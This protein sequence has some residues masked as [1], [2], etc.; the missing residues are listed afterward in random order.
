M[1]R[2]ALRRVAAART[3]GALDVGRALHG[4]AR[5]VSG[6]ACGILLPNRASGFV[7]EPPGYKACVRD[8]PPRG[9]LRLLSFSSRASGPTFRSNV[10]TYSACR[11]GCSLPPPTV[12]GVPPQ[13]SVQAAPDTKNKNIL[14]TAL[15]APL[16]SSRPL[17]AAPKPGATN[18]RRS[19]M[20]HLISTSVR[21]SIST[22]ARLWTRG[23]RR[24]ER[25]RRPPCRRSLGRRGSPTLIPC[26]A[27]STG[28]GVLSV[29][30]RYLFLGGE[31]CFTCCTLRAL[32]VCVL[33]F[34]LPSPPSST[35]VWAR[36]A[37]NSVSMHATERGSRKRGFMIARVLP[38]A[39]GG[40][41]ISAVARPP[42]LLERRAILLW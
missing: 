32:S 3:V 25:L 23:W 33:T 31:A 39:Y 28:R 19:R 36:V 10:S 1:G 20:L 4:R 2:L 34:L 12:F 15:P 21:S 17:C 9:A 27:A 11:R 5:R 26:A 8:R 30:F 13:H 14:L 24:S 6:E 37:V 38:A 7:D 22:A 42:L 16:S 18:R 35:A 29:T 40:R 41:K